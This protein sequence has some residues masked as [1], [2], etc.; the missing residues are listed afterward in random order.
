M[1]GP[2]VPM[3]HQP[4]RSVA[5]S[6]PRSSIGGNYVSMH[7]HRGHSASVDGSTES[8]LG[9]ATPAARRTTLDK[10]S[11][12]KGVPLT[13]GLARRQS[14]GVGAPLSATPGSRVSTGLDHKKSLTA[15]GPPERRRGLSD[16]G[17]TF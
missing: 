4:S 7:G 16:V 15:M 9:F 17:E 5:E 6:R 11:V 2:K 1:T 12:G 3:G 10:S 8:D 13:P 14:G